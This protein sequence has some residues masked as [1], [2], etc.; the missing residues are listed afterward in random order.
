MRVR[1]ATADDVPV[2]V[3]LGERLRRE[4]LT[5]WPPADPEF[6]AAIARAAP[7]EVIGWIAET[8]R[9]VGMLVA[10]AAHMIHSPAPIA[11]S[12][13]FYV[14][15]EHR[16]SR[17]ALLLVRAFQIW[18]R[19]TGARKAII[20]ASCGISEERTGRFYERMGFTYMGRLYSLDL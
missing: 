20:D 15:P 19:K 16:G 17:A 3:E 4:S 13:L 12:A 14:E 5:W 6:I 18:A 2:L 8:Q 9:P 11:R 10:H 7:K 1:R